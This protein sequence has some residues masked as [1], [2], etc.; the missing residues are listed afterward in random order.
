[1]SD[2]FIVE[3][4]KHWRS[5]KSASRNLGDGVTAT[6]KQSLAADMLDIAKATIMKRRETYGPPVEHFARTI[7]MINALFA[8]KLKEPLTVSDWPQIMMCDKMARHQEKPIE[9]N[10]VDCA[11]YSACWYECLSH[12]SQPRP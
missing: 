6:S 4:D 1:M 2:D 3:A 10:S 11:G 8:H 9:D 12:D 7:G 5:I